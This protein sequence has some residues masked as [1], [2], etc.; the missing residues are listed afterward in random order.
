MV[1]Q[2]LAQLKAVSNWRDPIIIVGAG[3]I[4][5][6]AALGLA[7]YNMP[8]LVLDDDTGPTVTGS[9]AFL[10]DQRTLEIL[11]VWSNLGRQIVELGITPARE[12]IFVHK[13]ALYSTPTA[14]SQPGLRYPPFVN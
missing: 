11:G 14:P 10:V 2:D 13:S 12:C 8:C 6:A 9:R 5:M 7:H 1:V 4:G 3:P